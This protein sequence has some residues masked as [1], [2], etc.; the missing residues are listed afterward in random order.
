MSHPSFF[1]SARRRDLSL[2]HKLPLLSVG[3]VVVLLAACIAIAYH[4][5]RAAA[6]EAARERLQRLSSETA[7]LVSLSMRNREAALDR[8]VRDPEIITA[9]RSGVISDSTRAA[10]A[11]LTVPTDSG[12][13]VALWTRDG[14]RIALLGNST[15]L[16][17]IDTIQFSI[18]DA[19]AALKLE[20]FEEHDGRGVYWLTMPVRA[21]NVVI[22]YVTQLRK[23][24]T[25][26]TEERFR[27]LLGPE[28]NVF[29]SSGDSIWVSLGGRLI[30][31]P[32]ALDAI[33][34]YSEYRRDG[35]QYLGYR[36]EIPSAPWSVIIDLPRDS[37][38][39]R[40]NSFLRTITLVGLVLLAIGVVVAIL[41][42]R[43]VTRPL[44]ELTDAAAALAH[45]DFDRRVDVTRDDELGTLSDA[46]NTMAERVRDA[47][48]RAE[49]ASR[50]KS[51][52]LASMSHEIRTPINAMIGYADLLELGL[53]GPVSDRQLA[54][55]QRIKLSGK[56]LIG[57]VDD[58]LDFARLESGQLRVEAQRGAIVDA[59]ATATALLQPIAETKNVHISTH[60]DLDGA[61][62][63]GDR[64]R[65]EQII[66]NLLSNAVKFT[67]SGGRITIRWGR[68]EKAGLNA[69]RLPPDGWVYIRVED[70]GIGIAP[71]RLTD[72][73]DPFIQAEAGY[74]R[75]KGGSGL[76]LTIS[77][78]LAR[79]MKGDIVVTS[80]VGRGSVFTLWMP[81]ASVR[82]P[83]MA[84]G[85]R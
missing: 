63:F 25:P 64:Q 4:Q 21:G 33:D 20:E 49:S 52:F 74:T 76:G 73:F 45:G 44:S 7:D 30:D 84:A 29:F 68:A 22:G 36:T 65:V 51:D 18:A 3:L 8:M 54:Q 31:A 80:T 82:R 53:A 85:R 28:L 77:R 78:R 34:P 10:L 62:Y 35:A 56:H 67:D 11:R 40:A 83:A 41:I 1:N 27:D 59:V 47:V 39:Q 79:L 12:L 14:R 60:A 37:I 42:A 2:R 46:F 32:I 19:P 69:G 38:L 23:V 17:N 70:N 5:V 50:A 75:T 15:E 43:Q 24:G 13:P 58:V 71:D 26:S 66:V 72:I 6:I 55:L 16:A 9:L 81:G 57:L 61:E 48:H